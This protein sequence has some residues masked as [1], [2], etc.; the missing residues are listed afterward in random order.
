[1]LFLNI[2][3]QDEIYTA[4]ETFTAVSSF[5]FI[6]QFEGAGFSG[7]DYEIKAY[8]TDPVDETNFYLFE[9]ESDAL[10]IPELG[11]YEDRFTN[12]NQMFGYFSD[13]E[14]IQGNNLTIR[15]YGNRKIHLIFYKLKI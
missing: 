14:I 7:E 13:E 9:F 2:L 3:Y 8:F 1:M 4:Q 10:S 15:N 5:D 11:V 6:E 12:G